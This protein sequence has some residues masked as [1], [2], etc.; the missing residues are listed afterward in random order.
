MDAI[1]AENQEYRIF[2]NYGVNFS[3]NIAPIFP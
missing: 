1:Q 2:S 3:D